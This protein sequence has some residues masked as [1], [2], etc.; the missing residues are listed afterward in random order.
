MDLWRILQSLSAKPATS[1][2]T[3]RARRLAKAARQARQD[4]ITR[5]PDGSEVQTLGV[6]LGNPAAAAPSRADEAGR[7]SALLQLAVGDATKARE[8]A[9]EL[10]DEIVRRRDSDLAAAEE[11]LAEVRAAIRERTKPQISKL[12]SEYGQ[13]LE[14]LAVGIYDARGTGDKAAVA[15]AKE[16]YD[17]AKQ[18]RDSAIADL[19]SSAERDLGLED[20]ASEPGLIRQEARADIQAVRDQARESTQNLRARLPRKDRARLAGETDKEYELQQMRQAA[21]KEMRSLNAEY[22]SGKATEGMRG[23]VNRARAEGRARAGEGRLPPLA[24]EFKR[25]VESR[26]VP[27]IGEGG[28]TYLNTDDVA[29][30]APALLGSLSMRVSHA[31]RASE[32]V[33]EMLRSVAESAGLPVPGGRTAE[34]RPDRSSLSATVGLAETRYMPRDAQAQ[35]D[36]LAATYDLPPGTPL[37]TIV[38]Y[39]A[40]EQMSR[41]DAARG[42]PVQLGPSGQ[43]LSRVEDD[44]AGPRMTEADMGAPAVPRDVVSIRERVPGRQAPAYATVNT[45]QPVADAS[46][47]GIVNT[48]PGLLDQHVRDQRRGAATQRRN[49]YSALLEQLAPDARSLRILEEELAARG[50]ERITDADGNV[51]IRSIF[52]HSAPEPAPTDRMGRLRQLAQ[53][54]RSGASDFAG[55]Y[56]SPNPRVLADLDEANASLDEL[57]TEAARAT[58]ERLQGLPTRAPITTQAGDPNLMPGGLPRVE[59][60]LPAQIRSPRRAPGGPGRSAKQLDSQGRPVLASRSSRGAMYYGPDSTRP[61]L[62]R[63][64]D[65]TKQG[66]L[67]QLLVARREATTA[68]A[69]AGIDRRIDALVGYG[70][71]SRETV[72]RGRPAGRLRQV[73]DAVRFV[74]DPTHTRPDAPRRV[75]SAR[76]RDKYVLEDIEPSPRGS[77]PQREEGVI[78][79]R[80]QG[81]GSNA[82]LAEE[83]LVFAPTASGNYV[84]YTMD[85][86]GQYKPSRQELTLDGIASFLNEGFEVYQGPPGKGLRSWRI[87]NPEYL[88]RVIH[89]YYRTG[90]GATG[91]NIRQVKDAVAGIDRLAKMQNNERFFQALDALGSLGNGGI[92]DPAAIRK[93][94]REMLR[95]A[96]ADSQEMSEL[97]GARLDGAGQEGVSVRP[98]AP[99]NTSGY[100]AAVLSLVRKYRDRGRARQNAPRPEDI[101][102]SRTYYDPFTGRRRE[103][104]TVPDSA[105]SKGFEHSEIDQGEFAAELAELNRTYGRQPNAVDMSP[106][107]QELARSVYARL[108]S[109]DADSASLVPSEALELAMDAGRTVDRLREGSV[110]WADVP[111]AVRFAEE[112][113]SEAYLTLANPQDRASRL[114]TVLEQAE[115]LASGVRKGLRGVTDSYN[116]YRSFWSTPTGQRAT[117]LFNAERRR[118]EDLVSNGTLSREQFEADEV[119]DHQEALAHAIWEFEKKAGSYVNST[120]TPESVVVRFM[121]RGQEVPEDMARAAAANVVSRARANRLSGEEEAVRQFLEVPAHNQFVQEAM[122]YSMTDDGARTIGRDAA[123]RP[124]HR[125]DQ[126]LGD[127]GALNQ[128]MDRI[129]LATREARSFSR[130]Y[131]QRNEV[132]RQPTGPAPGQGNVNEPVDFA[133]TWEREPLSLLEQKQLELGRLTDAERQMLE[134]TPVRTDAQRDSLR[135][136]ASRALARLQR[137]RQPGTPVATAGSVGRESVE[138]RIPRNASLYEQLRPPLRTGRASD[139]PDR[140]AIAVS[141]IREAAKEVAEELSGSLLARQQ[142]MAEGG[143]VARPRSGEYRVP[144]LFRDL[145]TRVDGDRVSDTSVRRVQDELDLLDARIQKL[146][147]D[148]AHPDQPQSEVRNMDA[149]IKRLQSRRA[150]VIKRFGQITGDETARRSPR[151]TFD[152]ML[153]RAVGG[154]DLAAGEGRLD[155]VSKKRINATELAGFISDLLA[156]KGR[157]AKVKGVEGGEVMETQENRLQRETGDS[158][159]QKLEG[160]PLASASPTGPS[161]VADDP[162]AFLR[163]LASKLGLDPSKPEDIEHLVS[164]AVEG[165]APGRFGRT[166]VQTFASEVRGNLERGGFFSRPASAGPSVGKAPAVTN[167]LDPFWASLPSEEA[168]QAMRPEEAAREL[169][170]VRRRIDALQKVRVFATQPPATMPGYRTPKEASAQQGLR[171][172]QAIERVFAELTD[173]APEKIPGI[174]PPNVE[175]ITPADVDTLTEALRKSAFQLSRKAEKNAPPV[176]FGPDFRPE[177]T[178]GDPS[179]EVGDAEEL[180]RPANEARAQAAADDPS[181]LDRRDDRFRERFAPSEPRQSQAQPAP[182]VLL[183]P[184]GVRPYVSAEG[185]ARQVPDGSDG[186]NVV[187]VAF[188]QEQAALLARAGYQGDVLGASGLAPKTQEGFL[189]PPAEGGVRVSMSRPIETPFEFPNGEQSTRRSVGFTVTRRY[190]SN[191]KVIEP[192]VSA[193]GLVIDNGLVPETHSVIADFDRRTGKFV[194]FYQLPTADAINA[195]GDGLSGGLRVE[196]LGRDQP[197][198]SVVGFAGGVGQQPDIPPWDRTPSRYTGVPH[199][200]LPEASRARPPEVPMDGPTSFEAPME[201]MPAGPEVSARIDPI[202][203]GSP[204]DQRPSGSGR[205]PAPPPAARAPDAEQVITQEGLDEAL[206]NTWPPEARPAVQVPDGRGAPAADPQVARSQSL[207]QR[208]GGA[209]ARN[210]GRTAIGALGAAGAVGLSQVSP[211]AVMRGAALAALGTMNQGGWGPGG[212]GGDTYPVAAAPVIPRQALV[213]N[214]V[215][216]PRPAAYLTAQNPLPY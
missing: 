197:G 25:L 177:D 172:F 9:A 75:L 169:D 171:I 178:L 201:P 191:G 4:G 19:V 128:A 175:T 149:E 143:A 189:P 216:R 188:T 74:L 176:E 126:L 213:L 94:G 62:L 103:G 2:K 49:L 55:Q 105:G 205:P 121:S 104:R 134:N 115:N 95:K 182:S 68:A 73:I 210:P 13:I 174:K 43:P 12:N 152:D 69:K 20:A 112:G 31:T 10:I 108:V 183:N 150:K 5:M 111:E 160:L 89:D 44:P 24:A 137:M 164:S 168:I 122:A 72:V 17:S 187:T 30:E 96:R 180:L 200:A 60:P 136:S 181:F 70:D 113:V 38:E 86:T 214:R 50:L 120:V 192:T 67:S 76:M 22:E 58:Q 125:K 88:A 64:V 118:K 173:S 37:S 45:A 190:T 142:Q 133:G 51:T 8:A 48:R 206:G 155:K 83:E 87:Q 101:D 117:E 185:V 34:P 167:P 153:G 80:K 46:G 54:V 154:T 208:I 106:Q 166:A 23:H 165:Q 65:E 127:K 130:R 36:A 98:D 85:S 28:T 203:G 193:S 41:M 97:P 33:A 110:S 6:T 100:D 148:K 141:D 29:R 198:S 209:V 132:P 196:M 146:V 184:S 78:V 14:R 93:A 163:A 32:R 162:S 170:R 21:S 66:E 116:R 102:D 26:L 202:D 61:S 109:G 53:A 42:S 40:D 84:Q 207:L 91:G 11:L 16:A 161:L 57:I 15:A 139:V 99:N 131:V 18:A 204:P 159:R 147:E 157:K 52:Q 3:A 71:S 124:M 212:A 135:A 35:M 47:T 59:E 199:I 114:A 195:G 179:L 56:L 77:I 158:L 145:E 123:G 151:T 156:P 215:R 82:G 81:A 138:G 194:G 79:L 129:I 7:K 107:A 63:A 140:P 119:A 92:T 39:I 90:E 27:R 144:L 211:D 1:D 186:S